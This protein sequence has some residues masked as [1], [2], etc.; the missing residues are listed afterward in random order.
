MHNVAR[1][2]MSEASLGCHC[3]LLTRTL[4]AIEQP[5]FEE[6][7]GAQGTSKIVRGLVRKTSLVR[8]ARVDPA[9]HTR[10]P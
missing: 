9:M 1:E 10:R 5:G 4:F 6:I 8:W 7:T 2:R 3:R